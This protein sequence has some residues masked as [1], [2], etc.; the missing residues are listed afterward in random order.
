MRISREQMLMEMAH[1]AS[2]RGTCGRLAVGAVIAREGR[3]ISIGY[4]GAPSG[5]PHC[6][7]E[8]CPDLSAPCN[9]TKHAE[10]NAIDFAKAHDINVE[11][12]DIY[13]TDSPCQ[14]CAAEIVLA[15]IRRVFFDRQYRD[16]AGIEKL[17]REDLEVTQV[18]PNGMTRRF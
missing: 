15:G 5:D 1:I 13:V 6:S 17:K 2:K 8:T 9:R 7:S 10:L 3:P 14:M 4:V 12:A 16:P 18:L 11:G